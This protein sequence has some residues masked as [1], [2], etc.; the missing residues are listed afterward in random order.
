MRRIYRTTIH[1]QVL[2]SRNL[3]HLLARAVSE[4]RE[5]DR[6]LRIFSNLQSGMVQSRGDLPSRTSSPE[7]LERVG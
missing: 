2:E 7:S 5:M 4:K 3:R 6:K 1:G